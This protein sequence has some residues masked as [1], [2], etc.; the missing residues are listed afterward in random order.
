MQHRKFK[1]SLLR[2]KMSQI[3]LFLLDTATQSQPPQDQSL[4]PTLTMVAIALAFFYFI[5]WR[6]EQKRRKAQDNLR[7]S[8]KK[9]DKVNAMGIL[10][11]VSKVNENTVVVEM[12]DGSKI[13][14]V[15]AAITE[16]LS[17]KIAPQPEK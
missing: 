6:P 2:K 7:N 1:T 16:V 8:L 15:K 12:V 11:T 9:G 13:E 3:A 5:L 17:E 4:Y 14:F 10:G